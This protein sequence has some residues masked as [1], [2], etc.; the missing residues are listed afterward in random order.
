MLMTINV[1][2]TDI[3]N[4]FAR[5]C[6]ACPVALAINRVLRYGARALVSSSTFNLHRTA[7]EDSQYVGCMPQEVGPFIKA[8]DR[9]APVQPFSFQIDIPRQFLRDS[10]CPR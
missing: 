3:T 1:T 2:Q 7:F 6:S 9:Y 10:L 4:G 5:R 8:F